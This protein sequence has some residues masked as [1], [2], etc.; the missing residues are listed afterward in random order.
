MSNT[1]DAI[2][3]KFDAFETE[4]GEKLGGI[5]LRTRELFS[6]VALT[7]ETNKTALEAQI[8]QI[9]ADLTALTQSLD[10][11]TLAD[12][13]RVAELL[14]SDVNLQASITNLAA[15]VNEN[16]SLITDMQALD[17]RVESA[18]AASDLRIDGLDDLTTQI[19]V[20]LGL[21]DTRLST[22]ES[23]MGSAEGRI[24][25]NEAA[26]AALQTTTTVHAGRLDTVEGR[27]TTI[28]ADLAAI[29]TNAGAVLQS[30]LE[31]TVGGSELLVTVG[32]VT[33]DL[34]AEPVVGQ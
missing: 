16:R 33:V 6:V 1:A 12:L 5:L 8:A 25:A 15:L 21:Y 31:Q 4:V 17:Q 10:A 2:I 19:N 23:R 32:G 27:V 26:I 24:T 18:I 14:A 29:N 34:L 7:T 20:T 28:V 30:S 11:N 13:Q 22:L 3:Q 9:N